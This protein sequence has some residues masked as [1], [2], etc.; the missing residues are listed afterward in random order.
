[1]EALISM[2]P[3]FFARST[4]LAAAADKAPP[5]CS[6]AKDLDDR[7]RHQA[8]MMSGNPRNLFRYGWP[9]AIIIACHYHFSTASSPY[10][11]AELSSRSLMLGR[12]RSSLFLVKKS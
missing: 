4:R 6:L 10:I 3:P 5:T 11:Y 2:F 9:I 7:Q 1:M 12:A 8:L